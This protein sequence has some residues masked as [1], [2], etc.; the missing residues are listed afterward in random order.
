MLLRVPRVV[1]VIVHEMVLKSGWETFFIAVPFLAILLMGF[2]RLD[3]LWS[4]PR[5]RTR[6]RRPASGMD[7]D[8]EPLLSDPDGRPWRA[9]RPR[10]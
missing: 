8:G 4:A 10:K 3:T 1:E 6:A 5:E 9:R 2:F 7:Q